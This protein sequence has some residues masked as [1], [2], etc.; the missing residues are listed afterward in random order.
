MKRIF[1]A[2]KVEPGAA[3]LNMI[4][5]LKLKLGNES[6]KW[7]ALENIHIT[8]VFLGDTDE[9]K[10]EQISSLLRSTCES[11]GAITLKLKG[12]GIFRSFNDPR[13]LWTGIDHSDK[14]LQLNASIMDG[15]K[16]L[17]IKIEDRPYN[18]HLT[19]GRLKHIKD[20][21]SLR[22]LVEQFRN[23]ELQ[24]VHVGDLVLF[25]SILQQS[26]PIYKPLERFSLV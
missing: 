4:S 1:I 8:L 3:L 16:N 13:I 20:L 24:T 21:D 25:E 2:V 14:L 9:G 12:C 11:F 7:T 10:I 6:V 22:S 26:G 5:T 17:N 19:L 15:L 18:P 23:S